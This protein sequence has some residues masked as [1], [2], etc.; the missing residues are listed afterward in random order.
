MEQKVMDHVR[1]VLTEHLEAHNGR[2][3]P[4]RYA[5][6]EAVYSQRGRFRIDDLNEAIFRRNGFHV[7]RATL[8]NTMKLF[9]A[10]RLVVK[11]ILPNGTWY[12]AGYRNG[13]HFYQVCTECGLSDE[14]RLPAISEELEALKLKRFHADGY[15]LYIYGICSSCQARLSR[16]KAT[17]K[18]EHIN[19]N[20]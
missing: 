15:A 13:N 1:R 6:L 8:F 9:I 14:L 4:E 10:L 17:V 11:H 7:C 12:E 19:K 2:K 5:I 16:R 18:K 20:K 3:T